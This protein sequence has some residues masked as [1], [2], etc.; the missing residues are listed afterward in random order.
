MRNLSFLFIIMAAAR[1]VPSFGPAQA[2]RPDGLAEQMLVEMGD[3]D[4]AVKEAVR[5]RRRTRSEAS[6][7]L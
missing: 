7:T 5:R 1:R 3:S 6:P 2:G 4:R